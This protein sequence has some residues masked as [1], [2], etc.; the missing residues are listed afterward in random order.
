MKAIILILFYIGFAQEQGEN[1]GRT[2]YKFIYKG[3]VYDYVYKEEIENA[4]RTGEFRYNEELKT[5]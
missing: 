3:H 4:I 5:I 2:T 1:D